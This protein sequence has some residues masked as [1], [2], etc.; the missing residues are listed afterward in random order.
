[1]T[2]TVSGRLVGQ[3]FDRVDGRAKVTGAA[4]YTAEIPLPGVAHAVIVGARIGSGAVRSIDTRRAMA[5][6]AVAV[7]THEN[8]PRVAAVPPVLP[9]GFGGP[10]PGQTFFPMQDTVI[11]YFGQ[12]IAVVVADTF[13]AAQ[14]A[15]E[16]VDAHYDERPA[17]MRLDDGRDRQYQ[18]DTVFCGLVPAVQSRGDVAAAAADAAHTVDAT[19]HFA[20]NHHNPIECSATAAVWDG[21]TVTVYDATQG[22]S[23][24]QATIAAY[25]GISPSNVRVIAHY[26]G[27]GF[28]AK[29][30]MWPHV[31][32]APMIA[33]EL[34]R[35]VKLVLTREQMFYGTGLREEQEQRVT[36]VC[37]NEGMFTGLRHHKLSVT[38]PFDDWAELSLGV[39][40]Q[41]YGIP[42]WEGRY[43][44]VRGNTMTPT[45]MRGPGETSGMVAMECAIDE[46]A[47]AIEIDPVELRLRNHAALDPESGHPWSSDGYAECL[48]LAAERFGWSASDRRARMR[49]D[50]DWLIGWGVATAGYPVFLPGQPQRAHAR[51]LAD[52]SLIVQAGTQDFGTGVAT[53]MAQVAGDALGV[54]WARVRVDIGDT[55]YPNIAAAVGSMGAGM[56]SAAVHTACTELLAQLIALAVADAESVLHGLPAHAIEGGGGMLRLKSDPSVAEAYSDLLSRNHL[57]DVETIGT[58][59]PPAQDLPYGRMSFGA[60]FAE[61]AVDADLGLVRVRR[62]VGAFA[63]GRVLNAKLARS[64]VLGGMNWG[65]SQALMEASLPDTR[66]GRWANSSLLEYLLPVNADAPEVDISFVE[67]ADPV[68][69]PLGVKGLGELGMVGAAAAIVNAVRHATG[70]TIREIPLRIEHLLTEPMT[71]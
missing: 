70:R 39:A 31:T 8:L 40:G 34:G 57:T 47:D 61:V 10:A 20:A 66:D 56:I 2:A 59:H 4:H 21:D 28:G 24:T 36:L 68:V 63:P 52:G 44:L 1:M 67:V 60:Q 19:Y 16:L 3:G 38:S 13:E 58:W 64:Q 49:R 37:D 51:L 33:R 46:L 42:N 32:L 48:H 7:F 35:P 54:P 27:G 65:L 45:F 22:V 41:A 29:A 14:Q 15:A 11:H 17:L 53:T 71:P 55:D 18:P 5:A 9:S 12:P 6:G 30:M 23:A 43:R 50:G 62:M 69:N 26:V 25:L